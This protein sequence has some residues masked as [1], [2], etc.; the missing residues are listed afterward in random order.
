LSKASNL[1]HLP[2]TL[3]SYLEVNPI[4][5]I[6]ISTLEAFSA[7]FLEKKRKTKAE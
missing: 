5:K 4:D 7:D 3:A 1:L 6:Y 2:M